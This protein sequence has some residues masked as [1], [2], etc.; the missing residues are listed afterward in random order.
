MYYI[1]AEPASK[2]IFAGKI[3]QVKGNEYEWEEREDC[4]SLFF[5]A[6]IKSMGDDGVLIINSNDKPKYKFVMSELTEDEIKELEANTAVR[7][8]KEAKEKAK[9]KAKEESEESEESEKAE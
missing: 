4:T 2:R 6:L 7:L 1:G 9:E 8:A 3:K 5:G